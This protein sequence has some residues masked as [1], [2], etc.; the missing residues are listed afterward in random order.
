MKRNLHSVLM[1]LLCVIVL[2][3]GFSAYA[4]VYVDGRKL[5]EDVGKNLFKRMNNAVYA[6]AEDL[7][8]AIN[9]KYQ[10]SDSERVLNI[11]KGNVHATLSV[12]NPLMTVDRE[13]VWLNDGFAG[14]WPVISER[15]VYVPLVQVLE[16]LGYSIDEAPGSG[17]VDI[18]SKSP[19]S[20]RQ[21]VPMNTYQVTYTD[22][23]NSGKELYFGLDKEIFLDVDGHKFSNQPLKVAWKGILA[24]D[25]DTNSYLRILCYDGL[26][27]LTIDGAV[28]YEG[29]QYDE[30]PY[31]F[32]KGTHTVEAEFLNRSFGGGF[33]V[34]R[35]DL[36]G[37][38]ETGI[39]LKALAEI[40]R[41][42]CEL[43][44]A[45]T[46][47]D[48]ENSPV[49][50]IVGKS[51]KPVVLLLSSYQS[52]T[53]QI[54][55]PA[56]TNIAAV[57]VSSRLGGSAAT[58]ESP[59][60]APIYYFNGLVN[61]EAVDLSLTETGG[62]YDFETA[63]RDLILQ[64]QRYT[65]KRLDSFYACNW[66]TK[67]FE[68][69]LLDDKRYADIYESYR[70]MDALAVSERKSASSVP[71]LP[72]SQTTGLSV[73]GA[74]PTN[75]FRGSYYNVNNPGVIIKSELVKSPSLY[76][77]SRSGIPNTTGVEIQNF[78]GSWAGNFVFDTS[79]YRSL[80][81]LLGS[82]SNG[83]VWV[84]GGVVY[85]GIGD[86]SIPVYF[87]AG[88]HRIEVQIVNHS[89]YINFFFQVNPMEKI[90]TPE[91]TALWTKEES[92]VRGLNFLVNQHQPW[93]VSRE[94]TVVVPK[95]SVPVTLFLNSYD[96]IN[97][98][99]QNPN[100]TMIQGMF[101]GSFC[102]GSKIRFEGSENVP[103][104]YR[105]TFASYPEQYSSGFGELKAGL[106]QI[107]RG[108]DTYHSLRFVMEHYGINVIDRILI[109]QSK[110]GNEQKMEQ[111]IFN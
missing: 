41:G 57:F 107:S 3:F 64:L 71:K 48:G 67:S 100:N 111:V 110:D 37:V 88:T 63:L 108:V 6:S 33:A 89:E 59:G 28:V 106:N 101:Y 24:F 22:P 73:G 39:A 46:Y 104:M 36:D 81:M 21:N 86:G 16:A 99:I 93:D 105:C 2:G 90:L 65:G 18:N 62:R 82:Q 74:V 9:G 56:G 44:F 78:G 52:E 29:A 69:V 4:D 34:E 98:V 47:G 30:I 14:I 80:D 45:G 43:S 12:G 79:G 51:K 7:S 25:Q 61:A 75:E 95:S 92:H 27:K 49:E 5:P 70:K 87:S 13:S 1:G 84:D 23:S 10:W 32:M 38:M 103:P 91:E 11:E 54:K 68:R 20:A 60:S 42:D 72:Y 53:W 50:I 55:N 19:D 102:V 94:Q 97:W 58:V 8:K 35:H 76:V 109:P 31:L 77:A 83:V 85:S 40:S 96:P 17:R 15:R 26:G 66:E